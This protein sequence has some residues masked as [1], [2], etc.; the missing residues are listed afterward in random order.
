MLKAKV[1]TFAED[2]A[3]RLKFKHSDAIEPLVARLGGRI[4]Y[5]TADLSTDKLPESIIVRA[6]SDFTIFLPS[7][8]SVVRDRFTIA[9]EL[10]HLFLHYPLATTADKNAVMVATRWVNENDEALQRAEWEANWFAAAFLMPS[11]DFEH[12]Y[13]INNRSIEITAAQF[14]VSPKAAEI[15]AQSLRI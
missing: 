7:I 2:V 4:E 12:A 9:H 3:R 15:R 10:G 11:T 8:T 5:K 13:K 6:L 1:H 14:G